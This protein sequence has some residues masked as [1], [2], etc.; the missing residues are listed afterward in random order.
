[1]WQH[2]RANLWLLGLTILLC[3]VI[4]P[5]LLWIVGQTVF[6]EKANGSLIVVKDG[7][8]GSRLIAQPFT[9]EEYFQPRPSAVSYN[10]AASGATN[11]GANNPLLRSRVA[12]LLGPVVK[13]HGGPK[14]GQPVAPDV[15]TW[16]KT[17][18]GLAATWA[19]KNPA[20][21]AAWVSADAKHKA[22]VKAWMDT[23]P[24][25]LAEWKK[26]NPG[27]PNEADLAVPFFVDYARTHPGQ[28]LNP[29]D[30]AEW[31]MAA[32]F[33]D[34]WLQ[35]H[36]QADLEQVPADMVMASGSGLDPHITLKNA[37]YQLDRVAGKWAK[38]TKKDEA[39]LRKEIEN[40]LREKAE[41]PLWGLAGGEIVNVLEVNLALRD[42]YL[43]KKQ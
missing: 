10:A 12:R 1:M 40:M 39:Q 19:E 30:S 43:S 36:P 11:W 7:P 42:R 5:S 20:V 14:K 29:A 27:D 16:F 22:A 38:E 21:A 25:A 18:P 17:Q 35:T 34:P 26:T 41:A 8:V 6:S 24:P 23:K 32:V 37:L 4:Y 31:T 9:G 13:Y 33:F 2:L 3:V 28:W 15:E